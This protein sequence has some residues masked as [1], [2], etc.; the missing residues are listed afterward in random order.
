MKYCHQRAP[1]VGFCDG[2]GGGGV[3]GSESLVLRGLIFLLQK[4]GR[5]FLIIIIM[6]LHD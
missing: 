4:N 2:K 5:I 1:F 3:I 6:L